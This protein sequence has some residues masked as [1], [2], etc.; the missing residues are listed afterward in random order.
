MRWLS[1]TDLFRPRNWTWR[2]LL[3]NRSERIAAKHLRKEGLRILARNIEAP[4]LGEIDIL[5]REGDT[6]VVV[7]V[8]SRRVADA[9]IPLDSVDHSKRQRIL[10]ATRWLIRR[11]NLAGVNIRQDIVAIAWSEN[12]Q[13]TDIRHIRNAFGSDGTQACHPGSGAV[14]A[15]GA[16]F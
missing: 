10:T 11:H 13:I 1:W 12:N 5:A 4:G 8:R 2:R 7:E 16:W 15:R 3:G 9:Q 6:L 14:P